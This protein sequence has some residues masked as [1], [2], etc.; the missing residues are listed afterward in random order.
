[1]TG[2]KKNFFGG[3]PCWFYT[4]SLVDTFYTESGIVLY[5]P[6]LRN[7]KESNEVVFIFINII[8]SIFRI[9]YI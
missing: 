8:K 3:K 1:M 9:R 4:P 5:F 2:S 7:L 6:G